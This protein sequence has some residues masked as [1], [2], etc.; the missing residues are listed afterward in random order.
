[1]SEPGSFNQDQG[2]SEGEH[3]LSTTPVVTSPLTGDDISII[4][5]TFNILHE[6]TSITPVVCDGRAISKLLARLLD[7]AGLSVNETA[8]RLGVSQNAVRQY[9]S[10]RRVKP[11]LIWFAKVVELCGGR[12]YIEFPQK[13]HY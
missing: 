6:Q 4:P 8:R 3:A 1:M 7:S 13:R 5:A 12:L 11:S 9:T 10:G 2:D